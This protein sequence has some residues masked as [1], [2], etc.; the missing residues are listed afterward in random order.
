MGRGFPQRGLE[1][2]RRGKC[3]ASA[4]RLG[5]GVHFLEEPLEGASP[6]PFLVSQQG[7]FAGVEAGPGGV[8]QPR[9]APTP[10]RGQRRGEGDCSGSFCPSR[11]CFLSSR[12][13]VQGAFICGFSWDKVSS[14]TWE[15]L[16]TPFH[17]EGCLA[18]N[19]PSPCR[20]S[21]TEHPLAARS[22]CPSLVSSWKKMFGLLIS[23]PVL[24]LWKLT[25]R[26]SGD[27]IIVTEEVGGE[28]SAVIWN[29]CDTPVGH[30]SQHFCGHSPGSLVWDGGGG[31]KG[32]GRRGPGV[33]V[34]PP[35]AREV[36]KALSLG[37]VSASDSDEQI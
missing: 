5:S 9:F 14:S 13:G 21:P 20:L 18:G 33:C 11:T 10:L 25:L 19:P 35:P 29:L 12:V 17:R 6:P 7:P 28:G 27:R 2:L 8:S 36:Q 24:L 15:L 34:H 30:L 26:A 32:E 22:R 4:A 37:R 3:V 23:H 31:D 1:G 16:E